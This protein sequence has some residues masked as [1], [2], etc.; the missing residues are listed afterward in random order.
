ML[1]KSAVCGALLAIAAARNSEVKRLA[2]RKGLITEPMP[3]EYMDPSAVPTNWD[4]RN[5]NGTN[6]LTLSLN[7]HIPVYCG[8]CWAHG[9]IS[10]VADRIK[11]LRKAAWPD[12]LPSI[13]V[14]LNCAQDIAGTCDGGDDIGVYQFLQQTGIPDV[15]CQ[16]YQAKDFACSAVNTCRT[17]DPS[18]TCSAVSN[19][20]N[21]RVSQYGQISGEQDMLAEIY[22]RGPISCGV[23]ADP[24][25]TYTGGIFYDTTGSQ[26]I[27]HI[28]AVVGWG[29]ATEGCPSEAPAPCKY[30]I[31]R[32][33]WGTYWGEQGF[34]RIIRGSDQ[35]GIES[36]CGWAVPIVA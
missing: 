4:W 33:S 27:N 11:I 15:T 3:S 6:F 24:I 36:G 18:G 35:I 19:Y 9:A 12:I 20:T 23:D 10:S 2:T 17:C 13:Q 8:S 22:A 26:D 5:V 25:E 16:Q 28:I 21:Y 29:V 34:M 30:W 14:I 7:Q 1:Y 32:N 31:V